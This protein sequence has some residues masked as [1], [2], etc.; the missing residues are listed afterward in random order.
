MRFARLF[1]LL[2]VTALVAGCQC[3]GNWRQCCGEK[4]C[5]PS[6]FKCCPYRCAGD[7]VI[8]P[9][10]YESMRGNTTPASSSQAVTEASGHSMDMPTEMDAPAHQPTP[11]TS[12]PSS[13]VPTVNEPSESVLPQAPVPTAEIR[14]ENAAPLIHGI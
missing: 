10:I 1:L 2:A 6:A 3:C 14:I 12:Q 4:P 9:V 8:S 7:A 5:C 13:E 11:A